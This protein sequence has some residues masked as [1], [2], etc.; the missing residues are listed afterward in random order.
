VVLV[1]LGLV[2]SQAALAA[3]NNPPPAGPVILNLDGTAIPHTYQSYSVNFSATSALTNLSFAFRE[4]P[5]FLLLDNVSMTAFGGGPNLVLNGD[6]ELGP[7]GSSAPTDWTYLNIFG[8]TFGGQVDSGCGN[9]GNCYYDGAVQAYDSIT[10]PIATTAGAEYTV[11]FDLSDNGPYSTFS[12]VSTNGNTTGT[13]GN[14]V[15][16]VVYGGALPTPTPE[17]ASLALFG[18]GLAGL[19]LLRRRKSA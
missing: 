6:F 15:N 16:L 14:G 19:G 8:A 18:V 1:G 2:A 12:A 13:G 7:V 3:N 11:T 5:A 17:P 9:P 4:D 10:Q